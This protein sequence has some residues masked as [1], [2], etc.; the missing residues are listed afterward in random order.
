MKEC[1]LSYLSSYWLRTRRV[2]RRVA[3]LA[4][5]QTKALQM[6]IQFLSS[7]EGNGEFPGPRK[8]DFEEEDVQMDG[9]ESS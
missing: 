8:K 1:T 2:Q 5:I 9:T 3:P 4:E 7:T 6:C